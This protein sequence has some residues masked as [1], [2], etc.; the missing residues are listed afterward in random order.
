[1][2]TLLTASA[3]AFHPTRN[4]SAVLWVRKNGQLPYGEQPVNP[5]VT[6]SELCY[7]RNG[8][9]CLLLAG[10]ILFSQEALATSPI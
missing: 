6:G 9:S 3:I 7:F 10:A 2:A 8:L 4:Y 5:N 1:M